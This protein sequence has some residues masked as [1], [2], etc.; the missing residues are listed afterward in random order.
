MNKSIIIIIIIINVLQFYCEYYG[1]E[2][3][4]FTL[5]RFLPYPPSRHLT[6]PAF[7]KAFLGAPVLPWRLQGLP[8][9]LKTQTRSVCLFE[10]QSVHQ[11]VLIG[12][13]YL[14]V[15]TGWLM[16]N[17]PFIGFELFSRQVS[18][19]QASCFIRSATEPH[20]LR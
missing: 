9:M 6:R 13:F 1:F 8:L 11:K 19:L 10:S 18:M 2:R 15:A 14:R 12:R 5:W 20:S 4:F 16:K 7:I 3:A 17:L